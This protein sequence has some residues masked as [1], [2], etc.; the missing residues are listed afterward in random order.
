MDFDV[1]NVLSLN[2]SAALVS[3]WSSM[4]LQEANLLTRMLLRLTLFS[5]LKQIK[6][7]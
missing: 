2:A 3:L 6:I 4:R 5:H 7:F 1:M